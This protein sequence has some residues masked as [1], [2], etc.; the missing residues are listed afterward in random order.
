MNEYFLGQKIQQAD[1]GELTQKNYTTS[2][3]PNAG[4]PW[5]PRSQD[6]PPGLSLAAFIP[7]FSELVSRPHFLTPSA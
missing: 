2:A 3:Q 4:M 6:T 7:Q 5:I 1:T